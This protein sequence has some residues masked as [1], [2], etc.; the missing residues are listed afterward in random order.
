VFPDGGDAGVGDFS[1][2]DKR[3]KRSVLISADEVRW[4]R[5]RLTAAASLVSVPSASERLS[6]EAS[7]L[8]EAAAITAQFGQAWLTGKGSLRSLDRR[9]QKLAGEA[10]MLG[11]APATGLDMFRD[12][13]T[14]IESDSPI[15]DGVG[16]SVAVDL[17]KFIIPG[18]SSAKNLQATGA[19]IGRQLKR[20]DEALD[21]GYWELIGLT[22]PPAHI[23]HL[24]QDLDDLQAIALGLANGDVT[25][26]EVQKA[27]RARSANAVIARAAKLARTRCRRRFDK[28]LAKF[29]RA[30]ES[31]SAGVTVIEAPGDPAAPWWPAAEIGL[32]VQVE[33][34]LDWF[35]ALETIVSEVPDGL[36]Q[37]GVSIAPIRDNRVVEALA[38]RLISGKWFESSDALDRI[39]TSETPPAAST[40]TA[41]AFSRA[42]S[43]LIT[44]S[45]LV[46]W[47]TSDHTHP[48]EQ[49]ALDDAQDAYSEAVAL[50]QG[51]DLDDPVIQEAIGV[52]V[53]LSERVQDEIDNHVDRDRTLAAE[54]SRAIRG[55][56][57]DESESLN[58]IRGASVFLQE[59]DLDPANARELLERFA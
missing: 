22:E 21:P 19:V 25:R 1:V 50:L 34:L 47:D 31:C 59:W 53:E 48:D 5:A 16:D 13:N 4:N 15:A 41:D 52:L 17:A 20:L 9:R 56:D 38:G 46:A 55:S 30:L 36:G 42:S 44:I 57:T 28:Q 18:L 8:E 54:I 12:A 23:Q 32:L 37:R 35:S 24:R 6:S 7:L 10:H 2:A 29:L 40:P 26:E 39:R 11:P 49:T 58:G 14:D 51:L 3:L 45:A 33:D 43:S 27:G